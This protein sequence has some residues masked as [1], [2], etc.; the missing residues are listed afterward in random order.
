MRQPR[1]DAWE[2]G[3]SPGRGCRVGRSGGQG[4]LEPVEQAGLLGAAGAGAAARRR[5]HGR[6]ARAASM[7]GADRGRAASSGTLARPA[8]TASRIVLLGRGLAPSPR[9]WP[10][11]RGSARCAVEDRRGRRAAR[12]R[13]RARRATTAAS[14]S[15]GWCISSRSIRP[16]RRVCQRSWRAPSRSRSSSKVS[17]TPSTSIGQDAVAARVG[18]G[19]HVAEDLSAAVEGR[20]GHGAAPLGR[21]DS[22]TVSTYPQYAAILAVCQ[23]SAP[24]IPATAYRRSVLRCRDTEQ[25]LGL[26]AW[27]PRCPASRGAEPPP[28]VLRLDQAGAGRRRRGAV[29]R[30]RLRQHLARRDRRR[31]P[32]HQG[33]ALPPLQ[34]QAGAVRGGLRAGR[35]R[36]LPGDPARRSRATATRGRRRRPACARSSRSSRSRA[37]GGS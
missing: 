28:A 25:S 5:R 30:E 35:E 9:R 3:R 36:R 31:R 7:R 15:I 4:R 21:T 22:H 1:P 26:H 20:P 8:I 2:G 19:D 29:H 33:R 6:R 16:A 27:C 18:R 32:G 14:R 10:S 24:V 13:W 11:S 12:R 34:R 23:R 17:A 37:T